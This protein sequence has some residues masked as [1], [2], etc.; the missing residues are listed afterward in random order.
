MVRSPFTV[1]LVPPAATVPLVMVKVPTVIGELTVLVPPVTLTIP[2]FPEPPVKSILPEPVNI[3][4]APEAFIVPA[5][6]K[7]P[8]TVRTMPGS[9]KVPP[10][11]MVT[12][13]AFP[14]PFNVAVNVDGIVTLSLDPGAELAVEPAVTLYQ[15]PATLQKPDVCNL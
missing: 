5:L 9:S 13:A 10:A 3:R 14:G 11:S 8:V 7:S 6:V 15:F 1:I 12:E 4:V 2:R